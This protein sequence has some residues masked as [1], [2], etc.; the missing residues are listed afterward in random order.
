MTDPTLTRSMPI[1]KTSRPC[2]LVDSLRSYAALPLWFAMWGDCRGTTCKYR[3]VPH[4]SV[5]T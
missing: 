5:T 3:G 2:Q 4:T 1:K